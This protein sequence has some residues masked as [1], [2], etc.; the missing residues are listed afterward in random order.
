MQR[1]HY[2]RLVHG[3]QAAGF[4][5]IG[6]VS[7]CCGS[8]G[9]PLGRS[10]AIPDRY[11]VGAVERAH[12]H[13]MQTNGEAGDFILHDMDFIGDTPEL[14]SAGRDR[15]QEIAARLQTTPFPV[16]IERSENNSNPQLDA[17]RRQMVALILRDLG[18]PDADQRTFVAVPYG[19]GSLAIESQVDYMRYI[20][21]RGGFGGANGANNN[22][23]NTAFGGFGGFGAAGR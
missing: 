20:F 12:F 3:L 23:T 6:I 14:N 9:M 22:G 8:W 13:T 15:V 17:E 19:R 16:I 21:S 4:A 1:R 18:N 2:Q 10:N 5:A 11:P 7:G